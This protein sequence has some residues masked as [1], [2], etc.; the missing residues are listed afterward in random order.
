MTPIV[1]ARS[2][3]M[4]LRS[5][6]KDQRRTS[7]SWQKRRRRRRRRRNRATEGRRLCPCGSRGFRNS[8]NFFGKYGKSR[9]SRGGSVPSQRRRDE[10]PPAQRP[11]VNGPRLAS[12]A[13]RRRCRRQHDAPGPPLWQGRRRRRRHPIENLGAGQL[14]TDEGLPIL[15]PFAPSLRGVSREPPRL[16]RKREPE[17]PKHPRQVLHQDPHQKVD[18]GT[19]KPG[20]SHQLSRS[21][22]PTS[23]LRRTNRNTLP[24]NRHSFGLYDTQTPP[25]SDFRTRRDARAPE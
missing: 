6:E 23:C 18:E 19:W 5:T 7:A 13:H 10:V 8:R 1:V 16:R 9:S 2:R 25:N 17:H 21:T 4:V 11:E 22:L 14:S 20:N 15:R 12:D 3:G 24:Q